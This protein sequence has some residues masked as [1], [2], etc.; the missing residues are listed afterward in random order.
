M[1]KLLTT[2]ACI[3]KMEKAGANAKRP[4]PGISEF[5][6]Q[7]IKAPVKNLLNFFKGFL[8]HSVY[9]IFGQRLPNHLS[10]S[11]ANSLFGRCGILWA[12]Y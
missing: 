7:R 6:W 4:T 8:F 9:S 3:C 11:D 5:F 12:L 2:A 10:G 1:E